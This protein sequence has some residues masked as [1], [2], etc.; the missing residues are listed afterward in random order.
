MVPY[1]FL[2]G[3]EHGLLVH[4]LLGGNLDRQQGP[5]HGFDAVA[6]DAFLE[7]AAE[8]KEVFPHVFV[9]V[10]DKNETNYA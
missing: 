10:V 2:Q 7:D 6:G 3:M 8:L 4:I 1:V 5:Q 9:V